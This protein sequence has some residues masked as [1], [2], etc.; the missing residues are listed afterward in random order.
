MREQPKIVIYGADPCTYCAA[1]R[2]LLSRKGMNFSDVSIS[3]E[4]ARREEMLRLCGSASVPQI[5]ID[6]TPIGGFNELYA[7][8]SS[9]E[10]DRLLGLA[11][12]A[13]D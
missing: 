6:D 2:M 1:A 13:P 9:G 5:V 3:A 4:P 12:T 11:D 7:L 8:D 10:L